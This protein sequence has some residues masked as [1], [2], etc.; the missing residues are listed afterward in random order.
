MCYSSCDR[1]S[2][3]RWRRHSNRIIVPPDLN[4]AKVDLDA[5]GF[6]TLLRVISLDELASGLEEG[7]G[8]PY[9]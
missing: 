1:A 2:E 3:H 9:C 8:H 6:V 5:Q 7:S 4:S